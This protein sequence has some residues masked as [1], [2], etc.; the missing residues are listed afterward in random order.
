MRILMLYRPAYGLIRSIHGYEHS[1]A[2][3]PVSA[4]TRFQAAQAALTMAS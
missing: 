2:M 4:T 3:R 1:D